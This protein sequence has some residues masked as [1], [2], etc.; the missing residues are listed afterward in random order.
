MLLFSPAKIN[1]ALDILCR[2]PAGFHEIQ[3]VYQEI[4]AL[5]DSIELHLIP[6]RITVE[7]SANSPVDVSGLPIDSHNTAYK[8]AKTMQ[9]YFKVDRG[10][11][12]RILKKIPVFSG[13]GGGSSNASAVMKGLNELWGIHAPQETLVKLSRQISMDSAFFFYGG[14]ALGAHFG[15]KIT[16]LPP[17]PLLSLSQALKIEI[18]D[19][20]VKV[21]SHEA[22][23]SIDLSKCG[24]HIGMTSKLIEGLREQNPKKILENLHND[25]E[26][27]VFEKFPAIRSRAFEIAKN[28]ISRPKLC[29]SGGALYLL[30]YSR[31]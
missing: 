19:T 30:E 5:A 1:L 27:S 28:T 11:E 9:E 20:A 14:T 2:D 7:F 4:P 16:V 3:T 12:I 26:E 8:A 24:K 22:Y 15:E 17:L 31:R 10:V 21:S 29:G 6:R 13:L 18:I 23:E 25:F